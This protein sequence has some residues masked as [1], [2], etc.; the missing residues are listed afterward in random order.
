MYLYESAKI[1]ETLNELKFQLGTYRRIRQKC[2]VRYR[3][4]V[5]ITL[6]HSSFK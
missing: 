5:M 4:P 3:K 6:N 1:P 2:I